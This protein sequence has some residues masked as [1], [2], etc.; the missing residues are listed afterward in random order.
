[1]V[2]PQVGVCAAKMLFPDGWINS[3]GICISRSGAA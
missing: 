3:A 2:D 1:M